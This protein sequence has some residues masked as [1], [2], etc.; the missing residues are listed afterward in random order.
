[1]TDRHASTASKESADLAVFSIGK[2]AKMTG[3]NAI[4]LRAW[5]RRYDIVAP[6][7]TEKGHRLYSPNDI[8]KIKKVTHLLKQGVKISRVK[9]LLETAKEKFLDIIPVEQR[10]DQSQWLQH[11]ASVFELINR[12]DMEGL[13]KIHQQLFA[14]YSATELGNMLCRNI[15]ADLA[16]EASK[17]PDS[18]GN[19]HVYHGFL[20]MFLSRQIIDSAPIKDGIRLLVIDQSGETGRLLMMWYLLLLQAEGYDPILIDRNPDIESIPTI[21]GKSKADAVVIYD[22]EQVPFALMANLGIP[23]FITSG[24]QTDIKLDSDKIKSLPYDLIENVNTLKN[25]LPAVK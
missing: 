19:Y 13:D 8:D 4:T 20:R 7:R 16:Q 18:S 25:V 5:E 10:H 9:N 21:A 24:S 6:Q 11:K 1:M 17:K 22:C 2:V 12:L 14:N 3:V 15:L 23:V